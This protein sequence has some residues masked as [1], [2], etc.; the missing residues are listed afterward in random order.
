M[1]YSSPLDYDKLIKSRK[2][3]YSLEQPFYDNETIFNRDMAQLVTQRWLLTDHASRIPKKGDYFLFEVGRESIIVIRSSET[4]I[5]AFFNVCRHRGSQLCKDAQGNKKRLTCPYHAWTYQLDGSLRRPPHM[6]DDFD[7]EQHNLHP[8]HIQEFHGFIFLCL[9]KDSPPDFEKEYSGFNE[10]LAF[11]G[12]SNAKVAARR[13]YPNACNWKLVVENFLECYHCVPAHAEYCS[14][15]SRDQLLALGAGPGSGSDTALAKYKPVMDAWLSKAKSLG[16]PTD[17]I[18]RD[19]HSLDMAQL[20][21]LPINDRE[22]SSETKDG[23]PASKIRMGN[24]KNCDN[25]MTSVSF[26][27]LGYVLASNDFAMVARFTPRSATQT[28]I[29]V[30]WL[31]DEKAVEGQDYDVDNLI[32]VWDVTI[33]QDK[34]ITEANY[35]GIQSD[36]YQPGPY[37]QQ[38]ARVET[39]VK[40]YLKG[41]AGQNS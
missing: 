39:F 1:T 27:P 12:F 7:P 41:I 3:G 22:Y 33:K 13:Q 2:K 26:N 16:H 23:K 28:D 17:M 8:C 18:D 6:P 38:E 40:W 21:R 34:I 5:K 35:A 24:F 14:V 31:V 10:V 4:E 29:E 11:H 20:A 32:W 9:S 19:E 37:S 30:I 25:G 15:H 36:R